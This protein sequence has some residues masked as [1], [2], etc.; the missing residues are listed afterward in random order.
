MRAFIQRQNSFVSQ[1]HKVVT[2][3]EKLTLKFRILS[4]NGKKILSGL[5]SAT[6]PS[7]YLYYSHAVLLENFSF[8][9]AC[10]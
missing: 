4:V 6:T 5:G 9:A 7:D 10:F 3:F 1:L 2:N 8:T